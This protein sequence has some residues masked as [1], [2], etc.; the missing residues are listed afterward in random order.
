MLFKTDEERVAGGLLAAVI[1][2]EAPEGTR[3]RI[4]K[5]ARHGAVRFARKFLQEL[6][7]DNLEAY[8]RVHSLV[9]L[10]QDLWF[11]HQGHGT[12]FWDRCE[13]EADLRNALLAA[14]KKMPV[15]IPEFYRGWLYLSVSGDLKWKPE[16]TYRGSI[17]LSQENRHGNPN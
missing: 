10:G 3:P 16:L 11:T 5:A 8:L 12:G 1:F 2:A 9:S 17:Y 7:Q 6:G 14:V 4:T 15:L 13:L